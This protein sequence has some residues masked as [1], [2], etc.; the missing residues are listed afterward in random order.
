[1]AGPW[2]NPDFGQEEEDDSS[3][4]IGDDADTILAAELIGLAG[5][6]VGVV[7]PLAVHQ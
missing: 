2:G 5:G 7:A 6:T 1:M 4:A 3:L